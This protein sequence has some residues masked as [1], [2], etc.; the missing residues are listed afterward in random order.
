MARDTKLYKASIHWAVRRPVIAATA[1]AT[2]P[3]NPAARL[4]FTMPK[5]Q[6]A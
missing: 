4:P 3:F 6:R 2:A 5:G 1:V